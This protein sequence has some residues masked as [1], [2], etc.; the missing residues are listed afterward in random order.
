MQG[1]SEPK[2]EPV[3]RPSGRFKLII[4]ANLLLAFFIAG[5][6]WFLFYVSPESKKTLATTSNNAQ[7]IRDFTPIVFPKAKISSDDIELSSNPDTK[8]NKIKSITEIPVAKEKPPIETEY[9]KEAPTRPQSIAEDTNVVK[10]APL[11]AIDA[12]TQELMKNKTIKQVIPAPIEKDPVEAKKKPEKNDPAT[13]LENTRVETKKTSSTTSLLQ[14][15]QVALKRPTA[16]PLETIIEQATES[17]N[18]SDKQRL[19][20][21]DNRLTDIPKKVPTK[22]MRP[23]DIH[24]SISIQKTNAIDDIMAAMGDSKKSPQAKTI[25]TIENR[26]GNL[27]KDRKKMPTIDDSYN[28]KLET[29]STINAKEMRIIT[30]Q[31]NDTLWDIAERAYGKGDHYKKILDANP[32]IKADPSLLKEGITLRAPL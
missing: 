7:K 28:K 9:S 6:I 10:K 26:I 4:M 25:N 1:N 2:I 14:V 24:N 31:K 22:K 21:V 8:T 18:E 11:S 17:L 29:E 16:L 5:I 15:N 23:S 13:Q 19:K 30:V 12:I 27:L 3:H 20:A 32:L